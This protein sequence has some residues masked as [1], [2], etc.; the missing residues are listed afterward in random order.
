[1]KDARVLVL[2]EATSALDVHTE[3]LVMDSVRQLVAEGRTV[4]VIAHRMRT[5]LW[6][7]EIAVLD[8]GRLVESGAPAQLARREHGRFA[9]LLRRERESLGE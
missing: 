7:D 6:V 5:V 1:M 3:S 8:G 9:A 2:D 4:V